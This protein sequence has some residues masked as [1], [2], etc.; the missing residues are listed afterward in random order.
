MHLAGSRVFSCH[1]H[2]ARSHSHACV[3]GGQRKA[4]TVLAHARPLAPTRHRGPCASPHQPSLCLLLHCVLSTLF[5]L[6]TPI[7]CP[8]LTYTP[9][10]SSPPLL[11]RQPPL[12]R[13]RLQQPADRT[14]YGTS[15]RHASSASPYTLVSTLVAGRSAAHLPRRL[16]VN[17]PT[18]RPSRPRIAT[19]TCSVP[20]Q[21]DDRG[22]R[23]ARPS[24]YPG[25]AREFR[26]QRC[27]HSTPALPSTGTHHS[28]HLVLRAIYPT[29]T[30]H[31]LLPTLITR[32]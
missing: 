13:Y 15:R 5:L 1:S 16:S 14:G 25:T 7:A 22:S 10:T 21:E 31:P 2:F 6:S 29:L 19:R 12:S 3:D 20:P 26:D 9:T 27:H 11:R 32:R 8:N 24:H 4:D 17:A 23:T 18:R 28:H 30:P